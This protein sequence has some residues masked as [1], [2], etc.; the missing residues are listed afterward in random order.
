[1]VARLL[2]GDIVLDTALNSLTDPVF[3]YC[4]K[5]NLVASNNAAVRASGLDPARISREMMV[6]RLKLRHPDGRA[7]TVDELPSTRA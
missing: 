4:A 1:M 2:K 6:Q 3:V 7:Y 5:G